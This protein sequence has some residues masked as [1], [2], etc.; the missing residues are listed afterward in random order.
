MALSTIKT[1]S[2]ANDAIT[3]DKI[4]NDSNLGVRNLVVNG[5]MQI[6]QRGTTSTGVGAAGSNGYHNLDRYRIAFNTQGALTMSQSAV[7]DLPGFANCMKFDCTTADTSTA[8]GEYF[9]VQQRFE[10]QNLQQL[11]KG[12]SSAEPVT[13][14]FY[15]KGNANATYTLELADADNGRLN[16]QAFSVTTSWTRVT[17]TFVGDTTGTLDDDNNH[18]F[19]CNIWIHA[20]STYSGGT[21]TSNVWHTATNQRIV[22]NATSF[23]DSTNRTLEITG[24]QVEVGEVATPFEHRSFGDELARCQ[25]YYFKFLEGSTKEIGVAWYYTAA[26]ASFML[27]YP[28]T[29]RATPTGIDTAGT[30]YY[31]IYR[32][33]GSDAINSI[34]FENGSTEQYSAYNNSEASGTAGQAGL[35][36]STNASAKVQF[37]AEL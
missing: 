34:T 30:G 9:L 5:A 12:T 36:R 24:W 15:V 20:G 11:K 19:Q 26:H 29:M 6:A 28:T 7:T 25:R 23:F 13:V 14:S 3:P 21:H 10:G 27:R 22:D 4:V 18:S 2:I 33:G 16:S 37:D 32:N 31:T 35:V 8:A 17:K 1:A